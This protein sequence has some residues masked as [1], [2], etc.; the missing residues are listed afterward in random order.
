MKWEIQTSEHVGWVVVMSMCCWLVGPIQ[1]AICIFTLAKTVR[2]SDDEIIQNNG[3]CNFSPKNFSTD[4]FFFR[5]FV[6]STRQWMLPVARSSCTNSMDHY[7]CSVK[8]ENWIYYHVELKCSSIQLRW[9]RMEQRC[10]RLEREEEDTEH[11]K[12]A[13]NTIQMR[14]SKQHQPKHLLLRATSVAMHV[15]AMANALLRKVCN[16][17]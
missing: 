7:S 6:C 14:T 11:E 2:S 3:M 17:N 5:S 12:L 1:V 13:S 4:F 8:K 9:T 16:P 10:C 15:A